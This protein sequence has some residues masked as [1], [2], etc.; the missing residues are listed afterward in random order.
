VGGV[1][2][3]LV[4]GVVLYGADR[5][6]LGESPRR[7]WFEVSRI[8]D[9]EALLGRVAFPRYL[10]ASAG[11][12]PSRIFVRQETPGWWL[13]LG[14]AR[15]PVALWLG[16]GSRPLPEPLAPLQACLG[17]DPPGTACPP[18]WH[19]L[20]SRLPDGSIVFV[21]STLAPAE[22]ARVAQG[23]TLRAR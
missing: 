14:P 18:G 3:T 17:P 8:A 13:G 10:P 20:S 5:V 4:L 6:L 22:V 9:A 7:G 1:A 21:L 19:A 12:P 15:E 23:L 2:W 16:S 11:W